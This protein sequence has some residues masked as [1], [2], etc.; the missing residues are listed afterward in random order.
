MRNGFKLAVFT[1]LFA[2]SF[3]RL[4]AAINGTTYRWEY[5]FSKTG[6]GLPQTWN[7]GVVTQ[8]GPL[9]LTRNAWTKRERQLRKQGFRYVVLLK[10]SGV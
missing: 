5:A 8:A 7:R 4:G 10:F 1:I 9:D 6:Q 2:L 3:A